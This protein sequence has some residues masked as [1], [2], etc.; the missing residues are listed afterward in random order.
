MGARGVDDHRPL[1]RQAVY[2]MY[3]SSKVVTAVAMMQLY[4]RG[5]F[6]LADPIAKFLPELANLEIER[7]RVRQAAP[8]QPTMRHLLTHTSGLSY[9]INADDPIDRA[10]LEAELWLS[11]DLD[12][13][14]RKVGRL[15][16]AFEPGERWNYSVGMDLAE[17]I[18]ERLSGQRF[19]QY[20]VEH[21]FEPLGMNDTGFE[22]EPGQRERLVPL[23]L[24]GAS[25]VQTLD[26]DA[27]SAR[28]FP[29]GIFT[30]GCRALCDFEHVGLFS[31]GAGLVSTARDFLRFGEMLRNGGE[32]DG[33]RILSPLTFDFMAS[34]HVPPGYLPA[35]ASFWAGC[36]RTP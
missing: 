8:T 30:F 17:L 13:F 16:L 20:L 34:A 32:L 25:G 14:A 12:E 33:V 22:L 6:H 26:P 31:G 27:A 35:G 36:G 11:A 24:I 3:S 10:Y 2:R 5:L 9:G 1:D 4:E 19:D 18:V 23:H 15:P 7:D 28:S 21:L 29:G